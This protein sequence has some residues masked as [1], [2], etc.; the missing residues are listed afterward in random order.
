MAFLCLGV[1]LG[2]WIA[3]NSSTYI[4]TNQFLANL[5][6]SQNKNFHLEPIFLP[7]VEQIELMIV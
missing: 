1:E 7:N 4:L 6:V 3:S 2:F 5:Q